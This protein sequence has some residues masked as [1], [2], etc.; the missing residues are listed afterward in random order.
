[1]KDKL[2]LSLLKKEIKP[3]LGC[4]E[5]GAI[6]LAVATA[7]NYLQGYPDK[8]ILKVSSNVFKN[9]MRVT[10]PNTAEK[11]IVVAAALGAIVKKPEKGLELLAGVST[12]DLEEA[13]KMVKQNKIKLVLE[14]T[15]DFL[16]VAHVEGEG[17]WAEVEL[18]GGHTDIRR[19]LVNG[20]EIVASG[21]Q[22]AGHQDLDIT[23]L[24][25]DELVQFV[26][27][28]PLSEIAF[29]EEGI[30]MNLDI[31]QKG[32]E[33]KS[34]LGLGDGYRKLLSGGVLGNDIVNKARV[35]VAGACDARM[36]GV[37]MPV[38]STMGSGNQGIG[39][40]VPVIVVA[41]EMKI[42]RERLIR[43]LTLSY[44]VTAYVKQ[45]TGKL[46]PVCGCSIAAGVGAAAAITWMLGGNLPQIGGAVKNLVGNLTGMICDGAKGGCA[47]KLSTSAAESITAAFLAREGVIIEAK[48]GI[49]STTVEKTIKNL[50]EISVPGMAST[51][52]T[53]LK[54]MM[55]ESKAV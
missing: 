41:Q 39:A 27:K 33:L 16:I 46:S 4:T 1:M 14:K 19:V 45:Q 50:H 38:M 37:N 24:T 43:A 8:I 7:S 29:L 44:V 6:A 10:V 49:V 2:L 28:V 42:P 35:A 40:S 20:R 21:R 32:L 22:E 55:E 17:G 12:I 9:A 47:L 54:V 15:A 52:D 51:D 11:G 36:A 5:P 48:D 34:G 3:A 30:A 53:I 25:M 23:C 18:F 13:H 26:E 31:S